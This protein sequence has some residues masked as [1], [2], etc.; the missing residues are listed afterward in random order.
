MPH[1]RDP[2]GG[3]GHSVPAANYF[4]LRPPPR[5]ASAYGRCDVVIF[6]AKDYSHVLLGGGEYGYE[7]LVNEIDAIAV[8]ALAERYPS[9]PELRRA[10]AK[11]N[12]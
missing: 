1:V 12:P 6:V 2:N 7:G 10:A 9:L 8:Q 11:L 5:L 3:T 4:M